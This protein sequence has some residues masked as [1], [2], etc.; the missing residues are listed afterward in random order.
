MTPSDE[1]EKTFSRLSYMTRGSRSFWSPYLRKSRKRL[2]RRQMHRHFDP[3][4]ESNAHWSEFLRLVKDMPDKQAYDLYVDQCDTYGEPDDNGDSDA[5]VQPKD[6]YTLKN[7][8]LILR[9]ED[10]RLKR[11]FQRIFKKAFIR[12][13]KDMPDKQAYDLYVAQRDIYTEPDG[14]IDN[15]DDDDP[16]SFYTFENLFLILQ[17]EDGLFKRTFE[18]FF[19]KAYKL[20]LVEEWRHFPPIWSTGW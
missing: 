13:L 20:D 7:L 15:Y 11:T 4:S 8:F 5:D 3:N 6:L 12:L 2:V 1:A 19:K 9:R 17:R 10:G 18:N 16:N 14:D